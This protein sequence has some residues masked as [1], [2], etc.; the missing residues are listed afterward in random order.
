MVRSQP[1]LL[2]KAMSE[3]VA[4]Q[5]QGSVPMSMAEITTREP[6]NVQRGLVNCLC[7]DF[8]DA[9]KLFSL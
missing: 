6:R 9:G 1:E 8:E 2:L 5:A 7:S 4:I 3:S